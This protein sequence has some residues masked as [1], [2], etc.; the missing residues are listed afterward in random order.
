MFTIPTTLTVTDLRRKSAQIMKELP[1]EK[2][3]LLVQ[4]SKARGALVDLEY[5][6]MLQAAYEEYMDILTYDEA[7]KEPTMTWEEYKK[8]R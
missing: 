7:E 2:L 4:N 8:G 1:E 3:Y 5:F 6:K